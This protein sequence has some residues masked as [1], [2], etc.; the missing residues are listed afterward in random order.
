MIA[1]PAGFKFEISKSVKQDFTP[2]RFAGGI[3][4]GKI[5]SRVE[6]TYSAPSV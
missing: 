5:L 3:L 6:R 4:Y 2:Y 1:K